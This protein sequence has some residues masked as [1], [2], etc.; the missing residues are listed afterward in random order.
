V[1]FQTAIAIFDGFTEGAD[2]F[3]IFGVLTV[4]ANPETGGA[5]LTETLLARRDR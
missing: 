5:N 4:I 1:V 2:F 3:G